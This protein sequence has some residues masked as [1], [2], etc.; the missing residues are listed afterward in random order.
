MISFATQKDFP[1]LSMKKTL[2]LLFFLVTIMLA[3]CTTTQENE[4]ELTKEFESAVETAIV[5]TIAAS[6]NETESP[7]GTL[8]PTEAVTITKETSTQVPA[9]TQ[10]NLPTQTIA[11]L[12]PTSTTLPTP[13]YRAELVEETIP[14]G[15]KIPPGQWFAKIWTVRNTGVCE[16]TEDFRWVFVEGED[17]NGVTDV[18][19]NQV[20]LPGEELEVLLEL[21]APLTAG[22]Y[23]G[24]YQIL[25]ETGASVTPLG[26]WVTIV[27]E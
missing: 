8:S 27:V 15:T 19:L 16:W 12:L 6:I 4:L 11:P 17:F 25:T 9:V 1:N 3:G 18:T 21:K 26:F 10:T 14:D 20:V 22:A 7:P 23:K 2:I 5:E 13:C 24:T